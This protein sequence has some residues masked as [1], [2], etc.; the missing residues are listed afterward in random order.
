VTADNEKRPRRWAGLLM[1]WDS[2]PSRW[3]VVGLGILLLAWST[4]RTTASLSFMLTGATK[5]TDWYNLA[6]VAPT[7]PY[8]TLGFRWSPPSAWLWAYL[9]APLGLGLWRLLHLAALLLI[10]DMRVIILAM[11][12]YPFW[13]DTSNGNILIFVLVAAWAALSG[14]RIGTIAF[15][16]LA[17]LVPRPLMLP[18]LIWLLWKRPWTRWTFAGMALG[19]VGVSLATGQLMPWLE[20]LLLTRGEIGGPYDFGPGALIGVWWTPIG[21]LLA[22]VLTWRGRLG[23]ASLAASPYWIPYYFLIL[24]LELRPDQAVGDHRCGTDR[25]GRAHLGEGHL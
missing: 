23:L 6:S 15:I 14:S 2:P 18:L 20:R 11:V 17:V 8:A 12:T 13:L 21:L 5:G 10:R 22:A 4:S 19:V 3:A 1:I 16:A 7:D 9:I 25:T 24:L